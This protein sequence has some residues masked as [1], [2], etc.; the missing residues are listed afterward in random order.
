MNATVH[1]LK[2]APKATRQTRGR[3]ITARLQRQR[4]AAVG[5][6]LVATVLTGLSLSHLAHGIE[7]VTHGAGWESW[8]MAVG[9]DLGFVALELSQIAVTTDTLR[10]KVAVYVKPAIIGT[11]CG[12]AVM[13]AFAFAANA[14]ELYMQVIASG[15]GVAVPLLVYALTRIGAT[16][17]L[18]GS[19]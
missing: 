11:L 15:F 5:L 1:V 4:L 9:I 7:I 13:N 16:L 8:C 17:Y 2:T 6:G 12:S 3:R 18:D 10:R 14:G 19:K